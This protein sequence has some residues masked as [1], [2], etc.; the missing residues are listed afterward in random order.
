MKIKKSVFLKTFDLLPSFIRRKIILNHFNLDNIDGMG[1]EFKIADT[2]SELYQA[3]QLHYLNYS[4]NNLV[5]IQQHP[6]RMSKYQLLPTSTVLVAKKSDKVVGTISI[7]GRGALGLPAEAGWNIDQ[8]FKNYSRVYEISALAIDPEAKN[9]KGQL[10]LP[11]MKY[12]WEYTSSCLKADALVSVVN[13][14]VKYFYE[15]VLCFKEIKNFKG[16]YNL[17]NDST[18]FASYLDCKKAPE[19]FKK[20]YCKEKSSKNIYSFFVEKALRN[21]MLPTRKFYKFSDYHLSPRVIARAVDE[22]GL[23]SLSESE[24]MKIKSALHFKSLLK[25][26]K[27]T[28]KS[29]FQN[30]RESPRLPFYIKCDF[31]NASSFQV[32]D[33]KVLNISR[34][35]LAIELANGKAKIGEK[36]QVKFSINDSLTI[37]VS[38]KVVSEINSNVNVYGIQLIGKKKKLWNEFI[39][40]QE[41]NI[42][43][44]SA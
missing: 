6:F 25:A 26:A 24:K 36:V 10:I 14:R 35:G 39:N 17:V 11:L 38:G 21:A 33:A 4:R 2:K 28:N 1:L 16:G 12:M 13:K 37:Q 3:F 20:I 5:A 19:L 30:R 7:I 8:L 31:K 40:Y 9:Y 34:S 43:E 15:D 29:S 32:V 23:S 27:L 44:K 18:P 41:H 42:Y 22:N